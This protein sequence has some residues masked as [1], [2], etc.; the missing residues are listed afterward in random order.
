MD[1]YSFEKDNSL[2]EISD[3]EDEENHD[4]KVK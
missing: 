4:S 2:G 3:E 1:D